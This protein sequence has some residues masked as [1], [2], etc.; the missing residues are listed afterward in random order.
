MMSYWFRLGTLLLVVPILTTGCSKKEEAKAPA[1]TENPTTSGVSA[2]SAPAQA[3]APKPP[4]L[5]PFTPPPL[6]EIDAKAEWIDGPIVDSLDRLTKYL[7]EHPP[8]A[9]IEEV[10]SLKNDSKEANE[11]ILSAYSQQ[12]KA[13]G[14][15]NWNATWNRCIQGDI[16]SVNPV[17]ISSTSDFDFQGA[18]SVGLIGFDWEMRPFAASEIVKSWQTSKDRL[19]DKFVLRD[20]LTW[21]DGKPVT[22]HDIAF[23]FQVIMDDNVPIRAVRSGTDELRWVHA[24]DDHTV[25]FFHKAAAATNVWNISFPILPKHI[26]ETSY[27]SDPSLVTSK[28]HVAFESKPVVSGPYEVASRKAQNEIVLKRRES[29]YMHNG[30]EVRDKPYFETIRFRVVTDSNTALLGLKSGDVDEMTLSAEQWRQQTNGEDFYK[31][32]TKIRDVEW[33]SFHVIWNMKSDKA[34]FFSDLKVRQAMSYAVDYDELLKKILYDLY[35]PCAGPFYKGAWMAPK[36]YPSPY[37]Q[38]L[39]K[40]EELLDA[41]GWTDSD[42]DGIRDKD[43]KV[44]EFNLLYRSD[45]LLERYCN[46]IRES[47]DKIGVRCNLSPLE[48]TVLQQRLNDHQFDAAFGGWGSGADPF[49]T[50]N[51]YG[52]GE[53][54]N[55]GSYSNPEVDKLFREAELEFDREKRGEIYGKI[56]LILYADQPYT[57]LYWRTAFY[58]IN[59]DLRGYFMSPRGPYHYGPGSSAIWRAQ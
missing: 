35:E 25:V 18:T 48:F 23:T 15:V 16:N 2:Q 26:F 36:D 10:S 49:T 57:W 4:S 42:G 21:S 5:E 33:T 11:K 12:P 20:D 24:Y 7:A 55:Y 17:L 54:R 1:P 29:Y 22:A 19:I 6:A 32:N 43:G 3:E 13:P 31:K 27:K 37:K 56:H 28:E 46:V 45:P 34:P 44:F 59:K 39:D 8:I 30:K 47:L 58:G 53:G 52:T 9:T 51:I 38:D 41:A 14:D 50:K 40:A